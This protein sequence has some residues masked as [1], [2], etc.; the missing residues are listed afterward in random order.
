[1]VVAQGGRLMRGGGMATTGCG[2]TPKEL[3]DNDDL[4]TALVLDQYLGFATH[5]MNVR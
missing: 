3:S 2:M 4:A 1:M 5:K